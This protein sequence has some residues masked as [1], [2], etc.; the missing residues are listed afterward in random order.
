M[1]ANARRQVQ[2][3][4]ASRRA[5]VLLSLFQ[6]AGG[7]AFEVRLVATQSVVADVIVG[8]GA[9]V[10][11]DDPGVVAALPADDLAT[12]ER[13]DPTETG[14]VRQGAVNPTGLQRCEISGGQVRANWARGADRG[15]DTNVFR[16][17]KWPIAERIFV[18]CLRAE[19]VYTSVERI[20]FSPPKG[21]W[22]AR[23]RGPLL[24][25]AMGCDALAA[26]QKGREKVVQFP[27]LSIRIRT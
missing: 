26:A 24:F 19:V 12:G 2:H 13:I 6:V 18:F 4:R 20:Q 15:A 10:R 17:D 25:G 8:P 27:Q 7:V 23:Q 14:A 16:P 22:L 1:R 9:I 3:I 21:R 11:N 5:E